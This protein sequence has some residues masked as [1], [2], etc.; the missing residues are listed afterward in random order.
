MAAI[1]EGIMVLDG[2]VQHRR[3]TKAALEASNYIPAAG[4][5]V[6]AT[7]SGE[8]RAGDGIHPWSELPSYDGTELADNL[9][10]ETAGKAL[11]AK[12]GKALNDRIEALEGINSIDC[13][14]ITIDDPD[15]SGDDPADGDG[16][17]NP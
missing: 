16:D 11:D 6:I 1:T 13:G 14:E 3:G 10:T 7:D 4:E 8:L 12:Q 2:P 15:A 17:S 9:T 5:I